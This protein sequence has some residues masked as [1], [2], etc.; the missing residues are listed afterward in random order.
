MTADLLTAAAD[1]VERVGLWQDE[2]WPGALDGGVYCAGDPVCL[3][4]ALIVAG[5]D[6][7]PP[8]FGGLAWS[9]VTRAADA[10]RRRLDPTLVVWPEVWSDMPGRTAAEVAAV[11]R[12]TA[13][14]VRVAADGQ[15]AG[16][17]AEGAGR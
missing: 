8:P 16:E 9:F 6:D 5:G 12:A 3:V 11:L 15:A 13:D 7:T 2:Y 14:A 1:L 17:A 4:G 10:V